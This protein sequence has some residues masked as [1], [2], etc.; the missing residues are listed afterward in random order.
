MLLGWVAIKIIPRSVRR[1]LRIFGQPKDIS[2]HHVSCIIELCITSSLKLDKN[3]RDCNVTTGSPAT[4]IRYF[5]PR[6]RR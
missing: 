3:H 2:L 5:S 4:L 1:C 6:S